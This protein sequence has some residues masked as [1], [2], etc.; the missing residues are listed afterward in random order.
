V[1]HGWA[2]DWDILA[3]GDGG[4]PPDSQM[5]SNV[6]VFGDECQF[7]F[8]SHDSSISDAVFY[9]NAAQHQVVGALECKKYSPPAPCYKRT[10]D[11]TLCF[12]GGNELFSSQKLEC[13]W[14]NAGMYPKSL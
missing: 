6:P 4:D 2:G 3:K 7:V 14:D 12:S 1:C 5:L 10:T 8:V 13:W 11:G 9:A